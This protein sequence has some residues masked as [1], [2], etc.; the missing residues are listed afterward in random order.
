MNFI[1]QW[2]HLMIDVTTK[3]VWSKTWKIN[4]FKYSNF[5]YFKLTVLDVHVENLP[6]LELII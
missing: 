2:L 1:E 5:H 6:K 4:K 3:I